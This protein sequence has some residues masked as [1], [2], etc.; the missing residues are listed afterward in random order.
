LFFIL[1]RLCL[2]FIFWV[3]I[4]VFL[5]LIWF[6]V[7]FLTQGLFIF[8]AFCFSFNFD[9]VK[10]LSDGIISFP[11][12][13]NRLDWVCW[14]IIFNCLTFLIHFNLLIICLCF[15]FIWSLHI[16]FVWL[17]GRLISILI[18]R[19]RLRFFL[20]YW[21][22]DIFSNFCL[23]V[24][25]FWNSVIS[26]FYLNWIFCFGLLSFYCNRL[27]LFSNNLSLGRLLQINLC[28]W[29]ISFL[30]LFFDFSWFFLIF[31][32]FF[33]WKFLFDCFSCFFHLFGS[34]FSLLNSFFHIFSNNINF[35]L[36]FLFSLLLCFLFFI[37]FL[38]FLFVHFLLLCFRWF[39]FLWSLFSFY[40]L[41]LLS[42]WFFIF[43]FGYRL[44][45]LD[46]FLFRLRGWLF[47]GVFSFTSFF[48]CFLTRFIRFI[49]FIILFGDGRFSDFG[50]RCGFVGDGCSLVV[51]LVLG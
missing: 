36:N 35:L 38:F 20:L 50:L 8:A 28:S 37:G 31:F 49:R 34:S 19:L 26:S 24:W 30:L 42:G 43:L 25:R 33:W 13:F 5:L 44:G 40:W 2:I 39:W 18:I 9:I 6:F 51:A 14:F 15:F 17:V 47:S 22:F 7:W 32:S 41:T 48:L 29:S 3:G 45:L 27:R 4:I 16:W 23:I 21:R 1:F 12:F 46:L 10:F 11:S